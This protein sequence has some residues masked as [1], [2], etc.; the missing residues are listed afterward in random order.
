M[1]K[2]RSKNL[3]IEFGQ[4]RL[5]MMIKAK[6]CPKTRLDKAIITWQ[7]CVSVKITIDELEKVDVQEIRELL[8]DPPKI[9]SFYI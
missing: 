6:S 4:V 7:E 2:R 3:S 1:T 5:K 9:S 8:D